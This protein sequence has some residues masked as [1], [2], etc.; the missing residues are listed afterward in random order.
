[1]SYMTSSILHKM[2][3]QED[4]GQKLECVI[5][6]DTWDEP[7]I[8]LIPVI[9]YFSPVQKQVHTFYQIDLNSDYEVILRFSA[10][11][12]PSAL[13]W[14]YGPNFKEMVNNIQIPMNRKKIATKLITHNNGNYTAILRLAEI[15]NEDIETHY[16]L[17]VANELGAAEYSVKLSKAQ[18]PI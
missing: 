13:M 15:T 14:S 9:V 2:F 16:K 10:N 5:T 1:G 3:N 17:H 12:Q 8:T 6:H 18:I 7:D 4:N 11:P